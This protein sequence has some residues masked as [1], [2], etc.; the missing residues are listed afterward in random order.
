MRECQTLLVNTLWATELNCGWLLKSILPQN[1]L[2]GPPLCPAAQD[3]L[4]LCHRR[5][6][7]YSITVRYRN[8][9]T[10]RSRLYLF[11]LLFF[12]FSVTL[13]HFYRVIWIFFYMPLSCVRVCVC[14]CV[15]V[16]VLYYLN[17]HKSCHPSM[18]YQHCTTLN[19]TVLLNWNM[20]SS[21]TDENDFT[22]HT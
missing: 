8:C 22:K 15:S 20:T 18:T 12:F 13:W 6:L 9:T 19:L 7:I 14:L 5:I 2:E 10:G 1:A 4:H 11:Y 21:M 3:F 17:R 16:C